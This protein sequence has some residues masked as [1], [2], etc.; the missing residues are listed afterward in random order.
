[1]TQNFGSGVDSMGFWIVGIRKL[2]DEIRIRNFGRKALG[3]VLVILG[4]TFL[5]VRASQA[6]V[7][8][9]RAN[10]TNLVR[11]HF[12]GNHEDQLVSL[13]RG[14]Q[15]E[16]QTGIPGG[17]LDDRATG[18]ELA[19][20]LG[21]FNHGYR[22]PILDRSP[23]ILRFHLDKQVAWPGIEL[24]EFQNRGVANQ[25]KYRII[26]RHVSIAVIRVRIVSQYN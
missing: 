18:L 5:H 4:V 20:F 9:H 23:R 6:H 11:A 19:L 24:L 26:N 12:V 15:P 7:D 10:M 13:L 25:L 14:N 22:D 1:M 17:R 3:V 2:V 8:A 16:T 21:G